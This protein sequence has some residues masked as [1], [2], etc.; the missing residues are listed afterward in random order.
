M[1]RYR[2]S[3]EHLFPGSPAAGKAA[4]AHLEEFSR[5]RLKAV[6]LQRM[7]QL[8]DS[9]PNLLFLIRF[10]TKMAKTEPLEFRHVRPSVCHRK[11]SETN[12]AFASPR[13]TDGR[14]ELCSW[15]SCTARDRD[16]HAVA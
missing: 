9:L 4:R 3:G 14:D 16:Y 8:K 13:P 12:G 7:P 6:V 15:C 1:E 2:S 5:I 11:S 10:R